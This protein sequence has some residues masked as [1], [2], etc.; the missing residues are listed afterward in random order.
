MALFQDSSV[1]PEVPF[2]NPNRINNSQTVLQQDISP[3][4]RMPVP[5]PNGSENT[6]PE[7]VTQTARPSDFVF[8]RPHN[9]LEE[10]PPLPPLNSSP[11][12]NNRGSYRAVRENI[13]LPNI[14]IPVR[15]DSHQAS[16]S[17][18]EK[19]LPQPPRS[20]NDEGRSSSPQRA[21]AAS[22][23]NGT[24]PGN[25]TF[26]AQPKESSMQSSPITRPPL[27]PKLSTSST[28]HA[29]N[30]SSEDGHPLTMSSRINNNPIPFPTNDPN[31]LSRPPRIP[32]N[33]Q[34]SAS[35][36]SSTTPSQTRPTRSGS[37]SQGDAIG[38][39][40]AVPRPSGLRDVLNVRD[41]N[42]LVTKC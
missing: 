2:R 4:R 16:T 42:L 39:S 28:Q 6:E 24:S 21:Q 14:S 32:L 30:L 5:D 25:F 1:A 33:R 23:R 41:F 27:P 26:P 37:A 13:G 38:S 7:G 9:A 34:W 20:F 15:K 36:V 10:S 29:S 22:R 8:P 3:P 40:L 11:N 35:D 31:G 12:F 17:D 19:D 18:F